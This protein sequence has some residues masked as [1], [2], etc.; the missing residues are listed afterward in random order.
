MYFEMFILSII[1]DKAK[2]LPTEY[3]CRDIQKH[4]TRSSVVRR[5][6]QE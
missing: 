6:P 5:T 3:H 4:S 2:Q 1:I